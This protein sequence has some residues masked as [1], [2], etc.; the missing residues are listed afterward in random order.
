MP[1][2]QSFIVIFAA[3]LLLVGCKQS[4][5]SKLGLSYAAPIVPDDVPSQFK[6]EPDTK[7]ESWLDDGET[8][9]DLKAHYLDAHR[10]G[11]E[12]AIWDWERY[13]DFKMQSEYDAYCYRADIASGTEALWIGYNDARRQIESKTGL[14]STVAQDG[15]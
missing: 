8:H 9:L 3:S 6:P 13:G 7:L 10:C 1:L 4:L 11:W 15:G 12:A 2:R 5:E 14:P